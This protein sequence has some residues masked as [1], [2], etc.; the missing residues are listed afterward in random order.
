MLT[1]LAE[2]LD[3]VETQARLLTDGA[4]AGKAAGSQDR[5]DVAAVI[6]LGGRGN[7][8]R[9]GEGEDRGQSASHY[10]TPG[11]WPHGREDGRRG[12]RRA[13]DWR[14]RVRRFSRLRQEG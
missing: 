13:T 14:S 7:G 12:P 2:E 10:V 8:D 9:K 11:C 1:A 4:V 3:R 6:D 5:L